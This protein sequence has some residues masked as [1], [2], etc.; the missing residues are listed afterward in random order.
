[1]FGR[2]K[3]MKSNIYIGKDEKGKEFFSNG[4][5]EL[6]V[7]YKQVQD[8]LA[9]ISFVTKKNFNIEEQ[10]ADILAYGLKLKYEMRKSSQL[11]VYEKS[12]IKVVNN[13]LFSINPKTGDKK[14]KFYSRIESFKVIP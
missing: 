3:I 12:L 6:R 14:K 2:S 10:I 13:K 4:F 5:R 11:A 9:E 1:V 7:S 8:V